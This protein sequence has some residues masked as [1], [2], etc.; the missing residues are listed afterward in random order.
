MTRG[1]LVPLSEAG[2]LVP[3][4]ETLGQLVLPILNLHLYRGV[5][6]LETPAERKARF[7]ELY[8][9]EEKIISDKEEAFVNLKDCFCVLVG[10]VVVA[11]IYM[12]I[13]NSILQKF[14]GTTLDSS[15][16]LFVTGEEWLNWL[17][18]ELSS[19]LCIF[20]SI[21]G[22]SALLLDT[23]K[24]VLRESDDSGAGSTFALLLIGGP[25]I[26]LVFVW[27]PGLLIHY[28]VD[29]FP[30]R[31]FVYLVMFYPSLVFL[32]FFI[33]LF[34][35]LLCVKRHRWFKKNVLGPMSN[36]EICDYACAF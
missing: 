12:F 27:V 16:F 7:K 23:L 24:A 26:E 29:W 22:A 14:F 3:A 11:L 25:L 35:F 30:E 31:L 28:F 32:M 21:L 9:K 4:S 15:P 34:N 19:D 5:F 1:R 13:W 17:P 10:A 33:R 20:F 36:E 2:P 6:Y 18:F 8:L